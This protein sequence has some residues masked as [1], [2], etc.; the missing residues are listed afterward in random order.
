M[1]SYNNKNYVTMA[2][3]RKGS[4]SSVGLDAHTKS[5]ID[6]TADVLEQHHGLKYSRDL[7]IRRSIL[8]YCKFIQRL[9]AHGSYDRIEKEMATMIKLS[10]RSYGEL[11]FNPLIPERKTI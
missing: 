4:R 8:N 5:Q 10:G 1:M 6:K 3:S 7:I 2:D 11:N 9:V